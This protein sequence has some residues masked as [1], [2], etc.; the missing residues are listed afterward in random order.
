M[1]ISEPRSTKMLFSGALEILKAHSN[2]ITR[3]IFVFWILPAIPLLISFFSLLELMGRL[4]PALNNKELLEGLTPTH[5]AKIVMIIPATFLFAFFAVWGYMI[6]ISIATRHR[7]GEDMRL[8]DHAIEMIKGPMWSTIAIALCVAIAM[9]VMSLIIAAPIQVDTLGSGILLNVIGILLS[10]AVQT[11]LYASI[12]ALVHEQRGPLFGVDESL[13]LTKGHFKQTF[14][15]YLAITYSTVIVILILI[16]IGGIVAISFTSQ[17]FV[18]EDTFRAL[19]DFST[20]FLFFLCFLPMFIVG[21]FFMIFE[22]LFR[23]EVYF[24]LRIRNRDV[25]SSDIPSETPDDRNEFFDIN[26]FQR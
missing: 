13:K 19:T 14:V 21:L 7:E 20:Q 6:M 15:R 12:P 1:I 5:A 16:G 4:G 24:D 11:Y 8:R 3:A 18:A 17:T 26:R 2:K 23:T 9:M 25:P 22:P 10:A